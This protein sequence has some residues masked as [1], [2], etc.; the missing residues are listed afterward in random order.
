MRIRSLVVLLAA[1]CPF[2]V[3]TPAARPAV[4]AT[5][6]DLGAMNG[7]L[8]A[9]AM[10]DRG[11]IAA[12]GGSDGTF[13]LDT[14]SGASVT[15]PYFEPR[16]V[17]NRGQVVGVFD[18]PISAGGVQGTSWSERDGLQRMP[19]FVPSAINDHGEMAGNC[20]LGPDQWGPP[21]VAV[22]GQNGQRTLQV[23][24]VGAGAVEARAHDINDHGEVVGTISYATGLTRGFRWSARD[25]FLLLEPASPTESSA[26]L[27]INNRGVVAGQTSDETTS[28]ATKWT[29]SGDIA[30]QLTPGSTAIDINDHGTTVVTT[31]APATGVFESK[32][33]VPDLGVFE[34]PPVTGS[35][36]APLASEIN[37]HNQVVGQMASSD[38]VHYHL[39]VWSVGVHEEHG[40]MAGRE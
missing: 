15:L 33:W 39:V 21:C 19:D 11:L 10:N 4:G 29:W 12:W 2:A 8:D 20:M 31:L 26:A 22:T 35:T 13:V 7:S 1:L 25:G 28:I 23:I 3:G 30:E 38:G 6:H 5:A 40:N 14:R 24:D 16:A 36:G 34:L 17:N 18:A 32:V 9:L 37:N 27:A